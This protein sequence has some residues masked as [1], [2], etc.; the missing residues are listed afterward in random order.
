MKKILIFIVVAVVAVALLPI[1]GNKMMQDSIDERIEKLESFG[2]DVKVSKKESSYLETKQHFE[3][4]L[5]DADKFIIFLNHYSDKQIPPYVKASL[6]GVVLGTDV[7][8]SNFPLNKAL[9]ID[10]YPLTLSTQMEKNLKHEDVEFFNFL[11]KFL[12]S[13][14][15]LY[16]I[17]YEIVSEEFEGYIRDISEQ[18]T[19]KDGTKI[20][21]NLKDAS[22]KGAGDLLAPDSLISSIKDLSLDIEDTST[23]VVV[24][25]VDLRSSANFESESTYIT[26]AQMKKFK[27][28]VTGVG[29]DFFLR[30]KE[31]Q[32]N[33]S[34][35]TQGETAELNA[36]SSIG[37]L[38][39]K[40]ERSA[41]KVENFSYDIALSNLDKNAFE[42]I[43]VLASDLDQNK[44]ISPQ[45][46]KKM[47]E[48]VIELLSKGLELNIAQL[49]LKSIKVNEKEDLKGFDIK[50][51]LK[52]KEDLDLAK[53][54]QTSPLS[55]VQ[56]VTMNLKLRFSQELYTKITTGI[57]STSLIAKYAKVDNEDV[58]F[59]IDFV[60]SQ[61]TINGKA[62][63]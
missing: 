51:K 55:L 61:L 29:E 48:S 16:H 14:G 12:H 31:L 18:Y 59:V 9:S 43:R 11:D 2:F 17:D 32:L 23:K 21:L 44:R 5:K 58:V 37:Q 20:Y 19:L 8:Y 40:S 42:K 49:Q 39:A 3:F 60:N 54:L 28:S 10:I 15:A 62:L 47:Q 26:A 63:R 41:V 33:V 53:K 52:V 46:Q 45:T 56:N 35:N 57:P 25:I 30:A 24:S 6:E 7:E 36:K 4:Q 50:A 22:F 38:I 34:S 1:V 13:K 27:F